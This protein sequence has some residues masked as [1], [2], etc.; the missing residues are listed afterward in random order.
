MTGPHFLPTARPA[1]V[2][3]GGALDAVLDIAARVLTLVDRL[4]DRLHAEG[5]E[6]AAAE[7]WQ[8]TRTRWGGRTYRHP[9]FVARSA[10]TGQGT[11]R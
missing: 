1:A 10:E 9:G 4:G 7:G 5:D 2:R 3:L 6:F 8:V 11:D